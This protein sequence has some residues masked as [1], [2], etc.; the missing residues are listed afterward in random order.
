ME[1]T[2]TRLIRY[3]EFKALLKDHQKADLINGE[4]RVKTPASYKHEFLFGR[5][6]FL[7]RGYVAA[8]GLGVVLGSRSLV[9][10]DEHNAFEPDLLFVHKSRLGIIRDVEIL[11][12]P[13]LVV[14]ILSRGTYRED[15]V[16]KFLGYERL[17]VR[18]YWLVD[19]EREVAEFYRLEGG[20]YVLQEV[21][22]GRYRSEALSGFW[23]E[24]RWLFDPK[25]N[26]MEVLEAILKATSRG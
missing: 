16:E 22:E 4:I 5:L 26:E 8:R 7:L 3:E 1:A 9:R 12:A 14:E 21:E 25:V 17:G 15:R 19:P 2:R 6:L 11:G 13:D 10:V 23:L 24:V 18:E 20:K